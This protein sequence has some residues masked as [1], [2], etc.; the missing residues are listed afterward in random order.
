[1]AREIANPGPAP[2]VALG[3]IR[4]ESLGVLTATF[5]ALAVG[6][7]KRAQDLEV[8]DAQRSGA[9]AGSMSTPER[10][11]GVKAKDL[12]FNQAA[13]QTSMNRLD[14]TIQSRFQELELENPTDTVR[15]NQLST[16]FAAPLVEQMKELDP[17]LGQALQSRAL[18]LQRSAAFRI[19]GEALQ[20]QQEEG[21]ASI[22]TVESQERIGRQRLTESFFSED[23]EE[24]AHA[25]DALGESWF[26]MEAL[27][28]M[29]NPDGTGTLLPADAIVQRSINMMFD[30]YEQLIGSFIRTHDAP[31]EVEEALLS[32]E[33]KL[34]VVQA[35]EVGGVVS[36][37]DLSFS[38]QQD[39]PV[40]A[41][42]RLVNLA[43]SEQGRRDQD[44]S[45]AR[46][47]AVS[48]AQRKFSVEKAELSDGQDPTD[49]FTSADALVLAR[50][51]EVEAENFMLEL[52]EA[53]DISA[54]APGVAAESVRA[55]RERVNAIEVTGADAP[56]LEKRKTAIARALALKEEALLNEPFDYALSTELGEVLTLVFRQGGMP[57]VEYRAA[58]LDIQEGLAEGLLGFTP[59]VFAENEA[60]D[61][62]NRF[63]EI[64]NFQVMIES[65]TALQSRY[66]PLLE[67]AV[68]D[69]VRHGLPLVSGELAGLDSRR[70]ESR[71]LAHA[72][73]VGKTELN[74][75]HEVETDDIEDAVAG[76][77]AEWML[78]LPPGNDKVVQGA[79]EA[80]Q[81]MVSG[82]IVFD[83][84]ELDDAVDVTFD[85]LIS[86][87][88]RV[89]S[90][91][92]I[93]A[94][95]DT[96]QVLSAVTPVG[97]DRIISLFEDQ[98]DNRLADT[99]EV[100]RFD[101]LEELRAG[102]RLV[103]DEKGE[104]LEMV[105][106]IGSPIMLN[107]G[108]KLLARY[109]KELF[110][111]GE[112]LIVESQL[113]RGLASSGQIADLEQGQ[114]TG[115]ELDIRARRKAERVDAKATVERA[116][117]RDLLRRI[118]P[119][120]PAGITRFL[121]SRGVDIEGMS[122]LERVR[123]VK[124]I[125]DADNSE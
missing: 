1:L 60:L 116:E 5:G 48:A 88:W 80:A 70:R 69:L 95:K 30:T 112:D 117:V 123:K 124:E 29:P 74:K 114:V 75:R 78:A 87:R 81:L 31:G 118:G 99:S 41:F 65:M 94:G 28:A 101:F 77:F 68:D 14:S 23:P 15:F 11:A 107:D 62:V 33:F 119:L 26:R 93:R 120:D 17:V 46:Q 45:G 84:K 113:A 52:E 97:F 4:D 86:S 66:G 34:P 2:R 57:E 125:V 22:L 12:A 111:I 106:A 25:A 92:T 27:W 121:E 79:I 105:N 122:A 103:T 64:E 76:K 72:I 108:S 115:L 40:E 50:G 13:G 38:P 24:V 67:R 96:E 83:A 36:E 9:E 100:A 85:A 59:R 16:E 42:N 37:V 47:A 61:F 90:G 43:R 63:N 6:L 58:M 110:E 102:G 71:V 54:E 53:R 104:G 21:L 44:A 32:D 8:L 7:Q 51:D 39:L 56:E 109:D 19:R 82:L 20:N 89:E 35:N 10:R 98:I 91:V 18:G 55:T 49:P 3:P 73:R